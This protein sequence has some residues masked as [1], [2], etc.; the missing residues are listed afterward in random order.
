MR[1]PEVRDRMSHSHQGDRNSNWNGGISPLY[2]NI[3]ESSKYYEWRDAVY[4]RDN[5]T[6]V[7]TGE[8]GNGNLNAHHIVQFAHLLEIH[9]IETF[10]QAMACEELWDVANGITLTEKTHAIIHGVNGITRKP[11]GMAASSIA[12]SEDIV[13]DIKEI[14]ASQATVLIQPLQ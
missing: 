9:H 12:L 7:I 2:K 4:A 14:I 8:K 6:D 10:E 3:R 1:I 5:Y 13:T 11:G